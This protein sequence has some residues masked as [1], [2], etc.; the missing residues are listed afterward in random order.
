MNY[1]LIFAGGSGTRVKGYDMPKQFIRVNGKP[2]VIYAIECFERNN[3]IDYISV[4][5]RADLIPELK[6]MINEY[7]LKKVKWIVAGG[8][9]GQESI[10]KGLCPIFDF[11]EH[12][13]GI[14]LVS[15]G[16]RPFV[17]SE[18]INSCIETTKK[19]GSAV[20]ACPVSETIMIV[21]NSDEIS[22]IPTK[23]KCYLS[24]APQGFFVD[25]LM[26]SHIRAIA[27]NW[28]NCTN[29]CE[30]MR[31]YGHSLYSIY[32]TDENIKITT[33]TDIG[34]MEKILEIK[35]NT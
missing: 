17:K 5:S 3:N 18:I 6:Q 15:D 32:D 14:V 10:Y 29:S 11:D 20:T 22:D 25:E 28:F 31:R 7:Q 1:A 27:E 33:D 30:L 2:V 34:I 9:S 23:I 19:Y 13:S 16:V 24:K 26:E 21:E 4:V 8:S 35:G 12:K